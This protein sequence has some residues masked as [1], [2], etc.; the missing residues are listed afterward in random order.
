[1]ALG[2]RDGQRRVAVSDFGLAFTMPPDTVLTRFAS[3]GTP[4]WLPPEAELGDDLAYRH[5]NSD[6][7]TAGLNLFLG[8]W[9]TA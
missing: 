4:G 1:M 5:A 6:V 8:Y 9:K 3:R 2:K 7:Y